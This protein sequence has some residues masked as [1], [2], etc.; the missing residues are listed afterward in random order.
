MK[1]GELQWKNSGKF[2]EKKNF[3]FRIFFF[4]TPRDSKNVVT[5]ARDVIIKLINFGPQI[6]LFIAP[7]SRPS[8]KKFSVLKKNFFHVE[9]N[10]LPAEFT[11]D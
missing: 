2:R 5:R 7:V 1:G 10:F 11:I 3:F 6:S 4:F 9:K 8:K